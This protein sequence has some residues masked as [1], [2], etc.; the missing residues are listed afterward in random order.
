MG[1]SNRILYLSYDLLDYVI[2]NNNYDK[3][4]DLIYDYYENNKSSEK[5]NSNGELETIII[6]CTNLLF[7]EDESY[8]KS[9]GL[10]MK[11]YNQ[12]DISRFFKFSNSL[13]KKF[14]YKL[15]L[16]IVNNY[17]LH[18]NTKMCEKL[19]E[20][21]NSASERIKTI[22]ERIDKFH[23]NTIEIISIFVAIIFAL[24]GGTQLIG[25]IV[26]KIGEVDYNLIIKSSLVLGYIMFTFIS[27]LISVMSWHDKSK[28]KGFILI[29]LNIILAAVVIISFFVCR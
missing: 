4:I 1:Y 22:N 20:N 23:F 7:I 18:L 24:Y 26:N 3:I 5:Y 28:N 11:K 12:T 9:I 13:N 25:N 8:L 21:L 2:E 15:K 6:G 14:N 16:D 27:A 19:D 29:I 10:K 17:Q